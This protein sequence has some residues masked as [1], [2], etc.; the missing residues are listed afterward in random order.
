M[1]TNFA[2]T[3]AKVMMVVAPLPCPWAT[4]A[5]HVVPFMDTCT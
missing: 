5:L 1:R 4:G 2:W 3:G